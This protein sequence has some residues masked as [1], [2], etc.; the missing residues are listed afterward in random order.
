ML[1]FSSAA[2]C[3]CSWAS[4]SGWA[5]L[6]LAIQPLRSIKGVAVEAPQLA[7]SR[8]GPF[9]K[10]CHP[11][12]LGGVGPKDLVSSSTRTNIFGPE[13]APRA[14]PDRTMACVVRSAAPALYILPSTFLASTTHLLPFT[15]GFSRASLYF[16]AVYL[17]PTALVPLFFLISTIRTIYILIS[18]IFIV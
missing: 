10:K 11:C 13:S 16:L 1:G 15:L 4:H 17:I 12:A 3:E 14:R 2:D 6:L 9:S 8:A 5:Y 7:M 18:T